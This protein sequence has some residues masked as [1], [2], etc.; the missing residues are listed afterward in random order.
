MFQ[1]QKDDLQNAMVLQ[2]V[3]LTS[4]LAVP[5]Q[6]AAPPPSAAAPPASLPDRVAGAG[7]SASAVVVCR[8]DQVTKASLSLSFPLFLSVDAVVA[9]SRW[10]PPSPW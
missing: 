8:D 2:L 6:R 5:E 9:V 7:S 4:D 10:R 3:T 1:V